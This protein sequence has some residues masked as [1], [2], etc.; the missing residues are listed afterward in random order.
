MSKPAPRWPAYKRIP[1]FVPVPL[2]TR[3]DGWTPVKQGEF[4]GWLAQSGSV[5]QA[6]AF[7]GCSRASAYALRRRPGA[8]DFAAAWEVAASGGQ[9]DVGPWK[10]TRDRVAAAATVGVVRVVMRRGRYVGTRVMLQVSA[11]LRHLGQIDRSRLA[12][13]EEGW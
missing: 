5:A 4:V 6:A 1:D 2:R 11:L 10:L 9:A 3:H 13:D 8:E 7:V 12:L